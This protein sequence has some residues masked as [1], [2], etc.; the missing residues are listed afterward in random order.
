M[1]AELC[2]LSAMELA[3]RIR[4]RELSPIEVVD[5]YLAR[6][7]ERN[8]EL[9]AYITRLDD[10]ARAAARQAE[11]ALLR[12]ADVG[13]LHGVPVAIK[14]L[15]DPLAG[16]RN[17]YGCKV[18]SQNI[19]ADNAI[20]VQRL[21][22][23]GAI[24]LGKTNTPEFGHKGVTDNLLFGPTSTPFDVTRNAGGSSGGSAAAVADGMAALAQGSDAG[25]S[26]RIPAAHCGVVGFKATVG[27][28]AAAYRPDAFLATPFLHAGPI[29]R[30]V[31][32]AALMSSVICGPHQRDP[33]SLPD[34]GIDW[35]GS[36][37]RSVERV[38][39]AYSCDLGDFPVEPAVRAVV[40]EAVAALGTTG[41]SV[42]SLELSLG[43]PHDELTELW[44]REMA[45]LYAATATNLAAAGV[46]LLRDHRDDLCPDFVA[47]IERGTTMSAV[48]AKSDDVLRTMVF[49]AVQDV[50]ARHDLLITATVGV[51]PF[52]NHS[53][54]QTVGPS[55]VDG[56]P[57]DPLLGWCLTHP[58]NF[59][60]HPAISVPAGLTAD[61]LP[62]GLQIVGRRFED[63]TVLAVAAALERARPWV[64]QLPGCGASLGTKKT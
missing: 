26:I 8:V 56:R 12:G 39:V 33:L 9:N 37:A 62:V 31:A 47:L 52:A 28:V 58:F 57:V 42:E 30:T 2:F 36:T 59:T 43:A 50:F 11:Q 32:D 5:A 25:G 13:P 38:S 21:L 55:V 27:R 23:A 4:D 64:Q 44:M 40:D 51:V 46:H 29:T 22:D 53:D 49:D 3:R 18:F 17:T 48:S 7:S 6:I 35:L 54:G 45:V 16:V 34:D 14:D 1:S 20:Y 10:Q 24:I 61:G 15:F 63:A 60:G 41:V 19:A